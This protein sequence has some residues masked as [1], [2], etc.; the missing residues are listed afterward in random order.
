MRPENQ[1][2]HPGGEIWCAALMRMNR[3]LGRELH[4]VDRGHEIGCRLTV[5]SLKLLPVG[6]DKPGFL[7]ARDALTQ[8]LEDL[9]AAGGI[10]ADEHAAATRAMLEAFAR[11]GMGPHAEGRGAHFHG[12]VAD[13]TPSD[14]EDSHES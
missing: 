7:D 11:T 5:D 9:G 6:P 13:F 12:I 3:A 2:P 8:A 1:E 14:P 4:D 10:T